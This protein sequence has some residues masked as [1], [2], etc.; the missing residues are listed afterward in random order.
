MAKLPVQNNNFR[1]DTHRPRSKS[2]IRSKLRHIFAVAAGMFPFMAAFVYAMSFFQHQLLRRN[3]H[4]LS[5]IF[6]A[7][8]MVS[9]LLYAWARSEK[10]RRHE[11]SARN[12]ELR[13][14]RQAASLR[15]EREKRLETTASTGM[16]AAPKGS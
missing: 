2:K 16:D 12:R 13:Q 4:Q 7:C 15:Q 5:A 3:L 8:G 10:L 6:L 11:V 9:L 1:V 14:R